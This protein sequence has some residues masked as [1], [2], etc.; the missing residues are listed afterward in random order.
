M[1]A[2]SPT[3]QIEN[4]SLEDRLY[5]VRYDDP[6]DSHLDVKVPEVCAECETNDCVKVCPANVWREGEDGVPQIAYENCLECS[7]CRFAC[8]YDNVVWEYPK[9]GGGMTFKHG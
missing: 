2:D 5:T 6:G 3:Q 8:G 7:S 4:D 1:S 9:T